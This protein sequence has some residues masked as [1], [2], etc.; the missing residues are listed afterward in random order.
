VSEIIIRKQDHYCSKTASAQQELEQIA[1]PVAPPSP[2]PAA[3][4]TLPVL[5]AQRMDV[6]RYLLKYLKPFEQRRLLN[7]S[8]QLA[9]MKKHLLFWK[10]T[11]DQC[12]IF[13]AQPSFR[14]QLET[15]VHDPSQQ[16]SLRL[17][18]DD[19]IT[20]VSCLGNVQLC[21]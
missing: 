12:K 2:I 14:S 9:E 7:T 11:K 17:D 20:D 6:T 18:G 16:L 21:L 10:L 13:Y 1:A 3:A 8:R 5:L 19:G 15:L 4:L